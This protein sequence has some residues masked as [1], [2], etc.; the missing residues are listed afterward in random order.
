CGRHVWERDGEV[1]DRST[2]LGAVRERI[3]EGP[4]PRVPR[5]RTPRASR[6]RVSLRS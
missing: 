3:A 6:A 2:V 1:L 5:A 4:A